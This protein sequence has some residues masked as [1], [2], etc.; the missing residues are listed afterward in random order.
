[1]KACA[2]HLNLIWAVC[3]DALVDVLLCACDVGKY[4]RLAAGHMKVDG[5]H[6]MQV[7]GLAWAS[8]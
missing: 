3:T 5:A 1:M 7:Q 2:L 4:L 6:A 8:G